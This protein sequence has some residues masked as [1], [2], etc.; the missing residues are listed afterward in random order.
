MPEDQGP[1]QGSPLARGTGA[2]R[3]RRP[4]RGFAESAMTTTEDHGGAGRMPALPGEGRDQGQGVEELDTD[5]G[6][7][8]RRPDGRRHLLRGPCPERRSPADDCR[9]CH[10]Q[11]Q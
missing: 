5:R 6:H 3:D 7:R 9:P 10:R 4:R 1:D 2:G 8:L 11:R